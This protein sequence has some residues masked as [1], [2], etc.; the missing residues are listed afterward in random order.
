[1]AELE[2]SSPEDEDEEDDAGVA[3]PV[4]PSLCA[5]RNR[6]AGRG[7][8]VGCALNRRAGAGTDEADEAAAE[9]LESPPYAPPL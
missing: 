7:L 5:E 8:L 6:K 4:L 1:M 9:A 2:A 3:P